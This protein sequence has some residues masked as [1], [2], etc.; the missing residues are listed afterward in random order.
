MGAV[1]TSFTLEC[2]ILKHGGRVD[3]WSA[4][5][6][7]SSWLDSIEARDRLNESMLDSQVIVILRQPIA[8]SMPLTA[9]P[10]HQVDM[11]G[12][13]VR[14]WDNFIEGPIRGIVTW[15]GTV[16]FGT[17]DGVARYNYSSN[18]WLSEWTENNGLPNNVEDAVYSM[19]VIGDD[20]WFQ[21]C[22]PVA[23]IAIR[24]FCS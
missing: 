8:T 3:T 21:P 17:E 20:L 12:N 6:S 23:G 13:L 15:D 7:S 14:S 10:L 19:E 11:N 16:L 4:G 1:G 2:L 9:T 18:T 5:T 22:Q 24:N